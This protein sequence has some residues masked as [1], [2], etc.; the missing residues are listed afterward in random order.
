MVVSTQTY[1]RALEALQA[2]AESEPGC[3]QV[4]T[5]LAR[6]YVDNISL[7]YCDVATSLEQAVVFA[8]KGVL[9]NPASQR[10]R[11]CLAYA[12]MLSNQIP[13][14]RAEA[15]RA[16]ALNPRSLL[17]MDTLG[18]LFTLLGEWERGS[19]LLKKAIRLNPYY[20]PVVHYGIWLNWFRQEDYEQA[21]LETQ[22]F[23]MTG[24]FWEPLA[25]AATLGQLGKIED[26][27][28]AAGALLQLKPEFPTRGRVLIR[29]FIK[30]DEIVER[31][32][33][34]LHRVGV[35]VE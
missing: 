20:R 27:Q 24:N 13:G 29:H 9:L 15:E 1:L 19:A 30:S 2:T 6:L 17:F 18:Y 34:G 23:L 21:H 35:H 25:L 10:A 8:E 26:G 3:G 11:T 33:Q 7:E 12:R 22:H 4:W 5:L 31:V 32:V 14:A 16:L 28:K